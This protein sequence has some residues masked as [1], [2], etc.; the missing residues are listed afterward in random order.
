MVGLVVYS[1]AGASHCY[2]GG[3]CDTLRIVVVL[4]EE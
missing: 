4:I 1:T 3:K 2:R